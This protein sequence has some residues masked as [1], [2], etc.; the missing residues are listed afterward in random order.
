[1]ET[2]NLISRRAVVKSS[3]F[4]LITVSIPGLLFAKHADAVSVHTTKADLFYRYPSIDDEIV[5]EVVGASHFNLD[6]VKALVNKRTELARATWDWGFGD[7]ETAIGAASHVGRR[8]IV[9]FLL[10]KGARPDI[11][12]YAMLGSY[13]SVKAMIESTPGIQSTFGPHGISLLQHAK[14][15]LQSDNISAQQKESGEKLVHYLESLGNADVKEKNLEMSDQEKEK[16]LGDY[17][18]GEDPNEGFTIRLNMR[19][20]LSL[21]KIGKFGGGL[22]RKADNIFTYNGITSVEI[23]FQSVGDKIVSLTVHEPD[24]SVTAMKI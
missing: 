11:F 6:R 4:G 20:L 18:Y 17:K 22:Y 12:T 23:S 15:G 13:E 14:N 7:W 3:V 24:L 9:E 2:Q 19:K 5:S 16:Y 21:G 10:S 1:M 8:D